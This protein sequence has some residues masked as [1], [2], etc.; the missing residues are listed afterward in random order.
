M[1]E[2]VKIVSHDG[3]WWS[4]EYAK[5]RVSKQDL[6][7]GIV[8]W[9]CSDSQRCIS[10]ETCYALNNAAEPAAAP[11]PEKGRLKPILEQARA[12]INAR[13]AWQKSRVVPAAPAPAPLLSALD[14]AKKLVNAG[15]IDR[16]EKILKQWVDSYIARWAAELEQVK[17]ERDIAN[18]YAANLF[19]RL[20]AAEAALREKGKQ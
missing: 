16:R 4:Q 19:K 12:D 7:R 2:R 10:A 20:Q 8:C 17:A 3:S 15:G 5:N 13:P 14:I 11:Q 18:R 6:R 9:E 1:S